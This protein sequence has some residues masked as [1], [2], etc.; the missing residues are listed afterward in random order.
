MFIKKILQ[1]LVDIPKTDEIVA[2]LKLLN[3]LPV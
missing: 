3:S 1:T 2:H